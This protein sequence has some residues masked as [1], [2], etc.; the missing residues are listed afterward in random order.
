MFIPDSLPYREGIKF[1]F[2]SSSI[3]GEWL[4]IWISNPGRPCMELKNQILPQ[5]D[6]RRTKHLF[7]STVDPSMK[8]FD[9]NVPVKRRLTEL[10]NYLGFQCNPGWYF[11]I[12]PLWSSMYGLNYIV[13]CQS[14]AEHIGSKNLIS[15]P[16]ERDSGI[17]IDFGLRHNPGWTITF[18]QSVSSR[19]GVELEQNKL[20]CT[21]NWRFMIWKHFNI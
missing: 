20:W 9:W 17:Q 13:I 11:S 14:R 1:L 4:K 2:M 16:Y 18:D 8:C 6:G 21:Y 19:E 3:R 7:P 5:A 12:A 15:Y 10:N